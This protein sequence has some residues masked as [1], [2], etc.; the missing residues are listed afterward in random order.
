MGWV[1]GFKA[2]AATSIHLNP[3]TSYANATIFEGPSRGT[4]VECFHFHQTNLDV[5]CF[6]F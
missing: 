2:E 4:L 5:L 1:I 3:K 6:Q